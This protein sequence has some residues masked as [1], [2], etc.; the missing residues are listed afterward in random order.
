MESQKTMSRFQLV[1]GLIILLIAYAPA[2]AQSSGAPA[3]ADKKPAGEAGEIKELKT[4]VE[5]L[6]Q[7]IEQQQRALAEMQKR[8]DEL[9]SA[10]PAPV[11]ATQPDGTQVVS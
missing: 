9:G 4:Q 6:Q 1:G 5:K 3:D 10:R 11:V 2:H 7:L 8:V